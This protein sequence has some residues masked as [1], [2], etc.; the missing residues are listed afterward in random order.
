M[1]TNAVILTQNYYDSYDFLTNASNTFS[2][3]D[4]TYQDKTTD[5]FDS[6]YSPSAKGLLTGTSVGMLDG[7]SRTVTALYYDARGR[8]VQSRA[9]NRLDGYDYEY[10]HYKFT[11]LVE[12][13]QHVHKSKYNAAELTENYRFTYDLAQ[14]PT[15]VYHKI[16][17]AAEKT[18]ATM[19]YNELGQLKQKI[20]N[21]GGQTIDYSY[22]IQ[23]WLKS[24]SSP[25]FSETVYYEEALDGKP[26]Y[27]NGNISSVKWGKGTN[28]NEKYYYTYDA[29][30]RMLKAQYA[31]DDLYNEEIIQYDKNG[32]VKRLTRNGYLHDIDKEWPVYP[33]MIDDIGMVYEGNQLKNAWENLNDQELANVSTNDFRDVYEENR[34]VKYLYDANG[35]QFAD[36]NKG[37]AWI[38]YN[39][40]NLPQTI[41]FAN[42]NKTEYMYDAA[43]IK[44][45]ARWSYSTT[46][47]NIQL[48]DVTNEI[49][50]I[51][52]TSTTDYCGAYVYEQGKLRR[53]L[54]P[55]GYVSA[56]GVI[57]PNAIAYWQHV[58]LLKDHLGNTRKIM[59]SNYLSSTSV[60]L[61]ER[62]QAIDYYPFGMEITKVDNAD[63]E[64]YSPGY[65]G[66]FV[67]PYLYNGKE[68]D[69]MHGLN[70]YDYGARFYDATLARWH[71]VDP[72]ADEEGQ[73]VASPY[74]YV[75][76]NPISR[77][78][79]DG[80][81]WG[82]IIGAVVGGGVELAGQ[83]IAQ[84]ASGKNLSDVD[85][86]WVDVGAATLE[87]GLTAGGSVMRRV[88]VTVVSAGVQAAFDDD[89]N[90]F[91]KK[92]WS[93]A[94]KEFIGNM[95]TAG[96]GTGTQK[97]V[98]ASTKEAVSSANKQVIRAN[99]AVTTAENRLAKH[100]NSPNSQTNVNNAKSNAQTARNNQVK[101]KMTHNTVGQTNFTVKGQKVN[102]A[103]QT[104][105]TGANTAKN[106]IV[107][108]KKR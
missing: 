83:A 52:T 62:P 108:E 32:N 64:T 10:L 93:Q 5:G 50:S 16:N 27:Y 67:T 65:M 68:M 19:S 90:V 39:L 12:K 58:Y 84:M 37:I 103:Q 102:V 89:K 79:P 31:P 96:V 9:N 46:E 72:S 24:I 4:L 70:E 22:N 99:N 21:G 3:C 17:T 35:N 60:A 11:G 6:E 25:A 49:N 53:I 14:R 63:S 7:S 61:T 73:E 57:T 101:T 82:N 107:D 87:G 104:A 2:G 23:G 75:E 1:G 71:S 29:H 95:A 81:I 8:V 28:Q 44:Q 74:C 78:D 91:N 30:N 55:E 42:G 45:S 13:K 92:E 15:G 88:A 106:T 94:G 43:G 77:T 54:T 100:P 85:I 51:G 18:L 86:D 41:Q 59:L 33:G 66:G 34:T 36:F 38:K 48:G 97:V 26:T 69:R 76:N 80:R 105:N 20:L 56:N 40:L 98:N 47:A